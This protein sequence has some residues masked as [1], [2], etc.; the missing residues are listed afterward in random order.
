[1]RNSTLLHLIEKLDKRAL[2]EARKWLISP[3]HNRRADVVAL[4][5][6]ITRELA[7][8][9]D[10]LQKPAAFAACYPGEAYDDARMNH[11]MSWLAAALRDYLAWHEWQSDAVQ[12]HL[13]GCRALRRLGLDEEFEKEWAQ[14]QAALDAQPHRDEQ[15]HYQGHLLQRERHEHA[16]LQRRAGGLPLAEMARHAD[17]AYRLNRL[18][19]ECSAQVANAV[20]RA[21]P[22]PEQEPLPDTVRMYE[23]LLEALR[24]PEQETAFFTAKQLLEENW[25]RFRGN[26]RRDLYLLALNFCIRKIN[27]GQRAFMRDA[28]DLYRS[29]LEN[30]ALFEYDHLS[31]FTYKNAVT[32]G[33]NLHEYDWV[34][35]FIE[36]YREHLHPRERHSAYCYNLAVWYFWQPDYDQ[37]M[38]LLHETNFTDPLTNLDARSILLRIYYERGYREA[39]ESHLDSFRIYLK[40][41]KNIGYQRDNYLN[42]IRF[43]KKLLRTGAGDTAEKAALRQEIGQ[44]AA[45]A[46]RAWLLE[47]LESL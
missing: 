42:L 45:L 31:R 35:R 33:L 1:M 15:Y 18:R 23:N 17:T 12:V 43:T 11:L 30:R 24:Q 46:E 25:Q 27:N 9:P 28:F 39:L 34:R 8:A 40:R 44:V 26:E 16:S 20:S 41:Q 13:A 10:C 36:A 3:A 7:K 14:A 38:T 5:D 4:F 32:A 37:A 6:F 29:G 47:R 19:Y 2:R 22:A 21:E